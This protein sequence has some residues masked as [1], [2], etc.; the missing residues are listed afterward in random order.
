[1]SDTIINTTT[2][3]NYDPST[4]ATIGITY[5]SD[6]FDLMYIESADSGA[7]WTS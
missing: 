3:I 5:Q 2:S 6:T 7:T 4:P 1:M